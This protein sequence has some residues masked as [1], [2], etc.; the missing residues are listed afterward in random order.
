MRIGGRAELTAVAYGCTRP[1][2]NHDGAAGEQ[3]RAEEKHGE[4]KP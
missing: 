3:R 4:E 1:R 2:D